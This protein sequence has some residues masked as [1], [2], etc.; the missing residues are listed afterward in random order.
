[1][2]SRIPILATDRAAFPGR[3]WRISSNQRPFAGK[4]AADGTFLTWDGFGS[5]F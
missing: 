1:M 5:G 4:F 3:P 2:S